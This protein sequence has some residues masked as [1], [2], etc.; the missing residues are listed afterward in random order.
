MVALWRLRACSG[1]GFR[2][3]AA[4]SAHKKLLTALVQRLAVASAHRRR[5]VPPL[6]TRAIDFS[7]GRTYGNFD[8]GWTKEPH[9]EPTCGGE[10]LPGN[11]PSEF[12]LFPDI[13]SD[14]NLQINP[15]HQN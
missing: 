8:G 14:M 9:L 2:R 10:A 6:A 12:F 11:Q 15:S 13:N 5:P 7:R 4:A 3:L 1:F